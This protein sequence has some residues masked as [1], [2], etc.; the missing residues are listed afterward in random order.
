[1]I[2][3]RP[4]SAAELLNVWE[5][6]TGL[7]S[8]ERAQVILRTAHESGRDPDPGQIP[9]G[10]RDARLLTLREW[11]FGKQVTAVAQ[12][13]KCGEEIELTFGVSDLRVPAVDC[14]GELTVSADEYQV[15]FTLP[16]SSDLAAISAES[17]TEELAEKRLLQRCVREA[18]RNG[19]VVPAE[20]LPE[21]VVSAL[22]DRMSELDP[23]AETELQLHCESCGERWNEMFDVE[24]FFWGEIQAWARRLLHD[25]HELAASYGWSEKEILAMSAGRRSIYLSLL[26]G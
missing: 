14:P 11:T 26:S 9:I 25:V 7:S 12:C 17:D 23:Q 10:E 19:E 24:P 15:K 5:K 4:L 8:P 1:M 3:M 16:T 6:A 13:P 22:S 2:L 20:L 18:V 21:S